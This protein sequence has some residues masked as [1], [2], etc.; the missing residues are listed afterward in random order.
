MESNDKIQHRL[1]AAQSSKIDDGPRHDFSTVCSACRATLASSDRFCSQCGASTRRTISPIEEPAKDEG[2]SD[3]SSSA[4]GHR[5][6]VPLPQ[7]ETSSPRR[8]RSRKKRWFRRPLLFIP[9]A[10][11]AMV[12]VVVSAFA[13]RTMST[14]DTVNSLS[15]PPPE[16]SGATLGGDESLVIDTNPALVAIQDSREGRLRAQNPSNDAVPETPSGSASTPVPGPNK[17]PATVLDSNVQFPA[18]EI[19]G[20]D[21]SDTSDPILEAG[22]V[23]TEVRGNALPVLGDADSDGLAPEAETDGTNILLMGV[24]AREGQTIDVGVRPDS[25]AILHLDD[26]GAC[27]LLAIPRDS[28]A[29]LPGYGQSKINHA[30]AVGGIEYEM[31]VVENY[32]GIDLEH[33]ALVDFEGVTQVVDNVGGITV[34]NPDAFTNGTSQFP[35]GEIQLN[36]EQALAY[37][38]FR[39]DSEGD[40]GRI[41]RQQQVLRALL[42]KA[43]S[44]NLVQVIPQSFSLLQSHFRTDFGVTDLL[45]LSRNYSTSCTSTSIETRT[46][47][48]DVRTLPD[49]MMQMDLSFVVSDPTVV[50]E[51]VRWLIGSTGESGSTHP[52]ALARPRILSVDRRFAATR[53]RRHS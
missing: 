9:L 40:F 10:I 25:L 47:P 14:L 26:S 41:S 7:S 50:R 30:L 53:W 23:P 2:G 39:G 45:N 34:T 43:A 4:L 27:R 32:L 22:A 12:A 46:I 44:A 42:D 13:Y 24:D 29:E 5:A 38:R 33:Y 35:K 49:D 20:S 51:H 8:R 21:P 48:G 6:F 31:L 28:R 15:T 37:A 17:H 1:Q 52:G 19:T 36:G 3:E 11:I 16:I 18:S